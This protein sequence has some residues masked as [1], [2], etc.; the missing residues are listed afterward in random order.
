MKTITL[1]LVSFLFLTGRMESLRV[2]S[3]NQL[4]RLYIKL[5]LRCLRIFLNK[6]NAGVQDNQ[7]WIITS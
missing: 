5:M 2:S 6:N 4:M 3:L 1:I 7:T